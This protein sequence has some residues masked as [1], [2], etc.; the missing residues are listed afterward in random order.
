MGKLNTVTNGKGSKD[1][2]KNVA[3]YR[4]NYDDIDWG[5]SR[6]SSQPKQLDADIGEA[7]ESDEEQEAPKE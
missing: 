6:K 1:R 4:N 2:V 3:G 7:G 5:R